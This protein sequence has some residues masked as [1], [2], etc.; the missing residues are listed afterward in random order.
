MQQLLM[1]VQG[2]AFSE[3]IIL[4]IDEIAVIE[5]PI[6]TRYLAEARKYNLALILARAIF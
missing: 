3:Q 4:V 6:L 2:Q 5:S 1:L